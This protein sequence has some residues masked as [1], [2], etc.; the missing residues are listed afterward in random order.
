M[1]FLTKSTNQ[2]W[3]QISQLQFHKRRVRNARKNGAR[4]RYL[5]LLFSIG[6][7]KVTLVKKM[8][9]MH[10]SWRY[11]QIHGWN[12]YFM[13][14]L[15]VILFLKKGIFSTKLWWNNG[16]VLHS[17]IIIGIS[18]IYSVIIPRISVYSHE[19][20]WYLQ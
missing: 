1:N 8:A 5:R 3:I 13:L 10:N 11:T 16:L 17:A 12:M 6:L 18:N 14:F 2:F 15:I 7:K 20:I 19:N 4:T 9:W